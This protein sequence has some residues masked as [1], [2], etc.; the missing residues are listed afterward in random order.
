MALNDRAN[1]SHESE[2]TIDESE[3]K[4][5][6]IIQKVMML[7]EN[8][9][10]ISESLEDIKDDK[11]MEEKKKMISDNMTTFQLIYTKFI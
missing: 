1:G 2:Y 3:Q 6:E 10:S 8:N 11:E 4:D 5:Y 9:N 7:K